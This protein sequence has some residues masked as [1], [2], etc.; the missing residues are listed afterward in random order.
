MEQ[1]VGPSLP[2]GDLDSGATR[3]I[4]PQRLGS[5]SRSQAPEFYRGDPLVGCTVLA[6]F[7]RDN[8]WKEAVVQKPVKGGRKYMVDFTKERL[9]EVIDRT[10]IVE[11]A[12]GQLRRQQERLGSPQR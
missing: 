11:M 3:L 5:P 6:R 9:V 4:S 12:P 7:P 1:G 2:H 8:T 10:A